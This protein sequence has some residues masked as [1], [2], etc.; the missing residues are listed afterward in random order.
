MDATTTFE[1]EFDDPTQ[2]FFIDPHFSYGEI[3]QIFILLTI[4]GVIIW[5]ILK[6]NFTK[7]GW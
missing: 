6:D 5:A 4:L 3:T 1:M 7:N 2:N